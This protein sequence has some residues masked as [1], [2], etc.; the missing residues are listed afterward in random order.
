MKKAAQA[1]KEVKYS[2]TKTYITDSG[3][4]GIF[5]LK[6]KKFENNLFY[7]QITN[8]GFERELRYT[9]SHAKGKIREIIK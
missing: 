2:I 5:S 6:F 3:L 1:A 7:F 4:G 8:N 9:E